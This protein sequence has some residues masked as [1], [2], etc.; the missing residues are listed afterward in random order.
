MRWT[1]ED[2]PLVIEFLFFNSNYPTLSQASSMK[3][4]TAASS[5]AD[6][7]TSSQVPA[8]IAEDLLR[9]L[10]TSTA[11]AAVAPTKSI[12]SAA[13]VHSHISSGFLSQVEL[14]IL[15]SVRPIEV[16]ETEEITVLGNRGLWTNRSEVLGWTGIGGFY[17]CVWYMAS[18]F[19]YWTILGPNLK[20]K[21]RIQKI[22]KKNVN[23]WK[24]TNKIILFWC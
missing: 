16:T 18:F 5:R 12:Q 21:F 8:R 1:N 6:S 22:D 20:W 24:I 19:S 15:R 13:S 17:L 4:R 10:R 3:Q 9:L 2:L 11:A 7:Y 14:A 23:F